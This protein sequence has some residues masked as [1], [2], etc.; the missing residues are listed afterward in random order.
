MASGSVTPNQEGMAD[1]DVT[2]KD[3]AE[4]TSTAAPLSCERAL[5][6]LKSYAKLALDECQQPM[7][8][9]DGS[10]HLRWEIYSTW[11]LL[12]CLHY[13]EAE[14]ERCRQ[15]WKPSAWRTEAQALR[16]VFLRH[17][18]ARALAAV[19]R[20]LRWS[21][22]WGSSAASGPVYQR[23]DGSAR[24]PL[25]CGRM[26]EDA[27]YERTCQALKLQGALQAPFQATHA[28][29]PDGPLLQRER[30]ENEDLEDEQRL[31]AQLW[32]CLRRG[33]LRGALQRCA[34][35]GQPWRTAL[36]Q[37]MMPCAD[38][39]DES[40]GWD[41]AEED[42]EEDLMAQ[43][44][45]DHT[46]WTELGTLPLFCHSHGN[47]WRRVWKEQCWDTAQRH[48]RGSSSMDLHEV[49]VYGFC[50]GHREA[51]ATAACHSWADR[52]WA[53]LHCLKEWLVESLLEDGRSTW[54]TSPAARLGEGDGG[55][56]D[57][58]EAAEEWEA[59]SR[60]LCDRFH[61][62]ASSDLDSMVADEVRRVLARLRAE[63]AASTTTG[64]S[65]GVAGPFT[66]L[67]SALIE[68]VWF[69][70]QASTAM[71]LLRRWLA[72][73][74]DGAPCSFL[75][76]QFA[77]YFAMWQQEC[78][79]D[80]A[81]QG[82]STVPDSDVAMASSSI[83]QPTP[84]VP[85]VDD[86]VGEL[87]QELV[88]AAS[89][90]MWVEKCL[91]GQAVELIVQH[92]TALRPEA[93]LD[94]YCGL[95]VLLGERCTEET[96][97]GCLRVEVLKRCVW[98][99][100]QQFP[101]EGFML[102]AVFV[103][104]TL[105]LDVE[106]FMAKTSAE[107]PDI[108][109]SGVAA[110]AKPEEIALALLCVPLFWAA[111]RDHAEADTQM[112]QGALSGLESLLGRQALAGEPLETI[113][114]MLRIGLERVALPLLVDALLSLA[115]RD[116]E[117]AARILPQISESPMWRDSLSSE[118]HGHEQLK[119]LSWYLRLCQ[120][121]G[122]ATTH[123]SGSPKVAAALLAYARPRLARDRPL[124]EPETGSHTLLPDGW[125]KDLQRAA[126]C[127]VLLML[128]Q[129][130]ESEQDFDG[131]MHDLAVAAAQS[132]WLLRVLQPMH[133]RSF[134][135]RLALVPT[136]LET[137][138]GNAGNNSGMRRAAVLGA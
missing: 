14:A 87:V 17:R 24:F 9:E 43:V 63:T 10:V 7:D 15:S 45:Q 21:H 130:F 134:L 18:S 61:G 31:L 138:C 12:L 91:Q 66:E 1:G 129:A 89:G 23:L 84:E 27:S 94:T 64:A 116:P 76:K 126:A 80:Q 51:L 88:T 65:T 98:A 95:L 37:G 11:M 67:Q 90:P 35:G 123:T 96:R 40:V 114:D 113:D 38:D 22:A 120:L 70:E 109:P 82:P 36:L 105:H 73:G 16:H 46:D 56:P 93:R 131:A 57:E 100:L 2:P 79:A 103:R 33:D 121:H 85:C 62:V 108:G 132:P 39:L 58:A 50:S 60:K 117:G 74:L 49:S 3:E 30:F 59:R 28:L 44:K 127:R 107:L 25:P 99:F 115:V 83:L 71:A 55:V 101:H 32:T 48:L 69:P 75:V 133:V 122:D 125:R 119:E 78:I 102:I 6:A 81:P 5:S 92:L 118:A 124:L 135:R 47:P 41:P 111:L 53:E 34:D 29:H 112:A 72:E 104:R 136:G 106:D 68:A 52:C 4:E 86:I 26:V 20:W 19:L 54:A 42:D 77:S 13:T 128:L 137:G 8:D 97:E 110:E